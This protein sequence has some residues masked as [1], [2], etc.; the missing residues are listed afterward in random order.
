MFGTP[1][2]ADHRKAWWRAQVDR[3]LEMTGVMPRPAASPPTDP[4]HRD[5]PESRPL[6]SARE[7]HEQHHPSA[8]RPDEHRHEQQ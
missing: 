6:G 8:V 2:A 5:A 1:D 4:I 3:L 7:L